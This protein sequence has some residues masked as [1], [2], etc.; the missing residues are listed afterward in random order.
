MCDCHSG[1]QGKNCELT[2]RSFK[3]GEWAWF[4]PLR[5]CLDSLLSLE[6]ATT[7]TSGLLMYSGPTSTLDLDD[8]RDFISIEL[9]DGD[10]RVLMSVGD[11]SD[12]VELQLSGGGKLT[13]GNWHLVEVRRNYTV[14]VYPSKVFVFILGKVGFIN[15]LLFY[16]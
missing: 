1:L 10:L 6:F 5:Q 16:N 11:I 15:I 12:I 7:D 8:V 13:N 14:C 2:T 9:I 3:H 4:S